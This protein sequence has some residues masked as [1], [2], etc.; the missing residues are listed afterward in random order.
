[1]IELI[2]DGQELLDKTND[3]SKSQYEKIEKE[4][5]AV[6]AKIAH[7]E[8]VLKDRQKKNEVTLKSLNNI[9]NSASEG[10]GA[11]FVIPKPIA[12]RRES[13]AG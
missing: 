8:Q 7:Y 9:R 11:A 6:Q 10:A 3:R 13:E 5:E 1:M 4:T 2:N 12:G